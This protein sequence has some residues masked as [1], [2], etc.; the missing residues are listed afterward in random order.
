MVIE[1]GGSTAELTL[2][3]RMNW[4]FLGIRLPG[5]GGR[6]LGSRGLLLDADSGRLGWRREV[7][8]HCGR[9]YCR[10]CHCCHGNHRVAVI[11]DETQTGVLLCSDGVCA[12]RRRMPHTPEAASMRFLDGIHRFGYAQQH[13]CW[14]PRW[15]AAH[16]LRRQCTLSAMH[17]RH[18]W[19][20]AALARGFLVVE[21]FFWVVAPCCLM[22]ASA[23]LFWLCAGWR[24]G[25]AWSLPLPQSGWLFFSKA[26][27]SASL[28]K[29]RSWP[30]SLCEMISEWP[31]VTF[32]VCRRSFSLHAS[33]LAAELVR[34]DLRVAPGHC[35]AP[36]AD[37]RLG[38]RR[39]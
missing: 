31:L 6:R 3:V 25:G 21:G 8:R 28:C 32:S 37:D 2:Q 4:L 30:P 34:D 19:T 7:G 22:L 9:A 1:D 24:P 33:Q 16:S 14:R 36:S 26:L 18:V 38:S 13:G 10:N 11:G 5:C 17:M 12:C 29:P 35:F 39:A 23:S 15:L 20:G 27:V